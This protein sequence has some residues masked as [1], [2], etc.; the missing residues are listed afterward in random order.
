MDAQFD[1]ITTDAELEDVFARSGQEPVLLYLHDPYCGQSSRAHAEVSQLPLQV[2]WINV[3][4]RHELGMELERLTGV[5]HES[6]Q[7]FVLHRRQARWSASHRGVTA[8]SILAALEEAGA[9]AA[10][11]PAAPRPG[12]WG[13]LRNAFSGHGRSSGT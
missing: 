1:E 7:A 10:I 4:A 12:R 5:R 2:A 13:A 8:A 3:H 6:P 9:P 11:S